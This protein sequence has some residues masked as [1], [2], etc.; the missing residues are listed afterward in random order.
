M[1]AWGSAA[2]LL[3]ASVLIGDAIRLLGARCRAAGPAVGLAVLIIISFATIQLPGRAVTTVVVLVVVSLAAAVTVIVRRGLAKP[4]LGG[5]RRSARPSIPQA[6]AVAVTVGVAA[7]GAA[8]PFIANGRVGLLGVGL[9]NDTSSH[10]IWAET[11]GSPVVGTRYGALPPG[12]PLGPHSLAE[13]MSVGLGVR[14]DMAFTGLLIATLIITAL[15]AAAA[16]RHDSP[17]KIPL[18]GV[19]GSLL[20]LVAAYYAEAAF[21]EMLVGLF[22]LALVLHLKEVRTEWAARERP[23]WQ[24]LIPA[25][26]LV[27]AAL[28]VYSYLALAWIGLTL[29]IWLFAEVVSRPGWLRRWRVLAVELALGAAIAGGIVVLLVL[30][31]IGHIVSFAGSIGLSPASTGAIPVTNVGNIPHALPGWEALGIWNSPDFRFHPANALHTDL[32]SWFALGV[33]VF[34]MGWAI[35][36]REFLLP[37]AIGACAIVF[38]RAGQGQSPY[39]TAKALVIAGP[40]VAVTGLR[41]LLQAPLAPMPRLAVVAR[42]LA[43]AVFVL[44]AGYSSYQ[45][46]RNEPVWPPESTRELMAFDQLTRGQTVLF[47]G[48]S[49]YAAWIFHDSEMSSAP[50]TLSMEQVSIRSTKPNTYGTQVDWDSIDLRTINRFTWAVTPNTAYASQAPAGFRLVRRLPM[51]ELWRRTATI[52]PRDALD[53]PGAPGAIFDCKNPAERQLSRQRGV[54]A[55]MSPPVSATL[56]SPGMPPGSAALVPPGGFDSTTLRLPAGRWDIALQYL[57]PVPLDV[58]VGDVVRVMPP[59]LERP[60]PYF[61]V[62]SIESSGAPLIMLIRARRPSS[63][64]GGDLA[65]LPSRV[66]ATRSPDRR[67]LVPLSRACGRYVDWFRTET[68]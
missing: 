7:V 14:L 58:V 49:D 20:Y 35:R 42:Y 38:W 22:L 29:V 15:V 19:M 21:K 18:V 4:W 47:L 34:G 33:L 40:V 54:A 1:E 13:A 55:V 43:A 45:A 51:Y 10:L 36:R 50:G 28:Y 67:T 11:L 30:P 63:I 37:A 57:S 24:S 6:V 26:L 25:S 31:A 39:V 62:G 41:G 3:A 60:G 48:N 17:W 32:L 23:L 66:V 65:A 52:Q 44:F 2:V 64:S 68:S 12:Y 16:L 9:D 8:L 53:P 46:L 27:A 5:S 56:S 61:S 59:Y